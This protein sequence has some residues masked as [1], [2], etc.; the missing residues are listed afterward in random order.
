M[1]LYARKLGEL[2]IPHQVT[3]G[4]ALGQV[5]EL[6]WLAKCLAAVTD[7]ENPIALVAVLRGEL[8]G[9]SDT[10]LYAFRKAGG[11]FDYRTEIPTAGM[12]AEHAALFQDAFARLQ[13]YALWF[14][15]L[16]AIAAIERI[17]ADLGL[18]MRAAAAVGGNVQA[19]SLAKALETLRAAQAEL[20]S[21]ADLVAHLERLINENRE[22]DGLPARPHDASAVRLMNL[23]KV[24]GLGVA[25][26][27]SVRPHRRVRPRRRLVHQ[28][29]GKSWSRDI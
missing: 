4:K 11:R 15:R 19:G 9:A 5:S 25:G 26:R 2:G 20:Y 23:H 7:P 8:F 6:A 29:L 18:P 14:K 10:A 1:S 24:K 3:G 16:P 17:A 22:F 28:P 12:N 27:V 21:T 13:R